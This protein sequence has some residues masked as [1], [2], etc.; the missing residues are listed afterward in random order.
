M[1][2]IIMVLHL[3]SIIV[4]IKLVPEAITE[5]SYKS[6]TFHYSTNQ[7]GKKVRLKGQNCIYIPL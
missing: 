2:K 3:H 1:Q 7:M 4:L 5:T 6:F